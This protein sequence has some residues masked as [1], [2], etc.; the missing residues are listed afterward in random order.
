MAS[1]TIEKGNRIETGKR[2]SLG[3]NPVL[4]GR[5]SY[6]NEP[7]I[8]LSDEHISR[9][10]AEITFTQDTFYI[11]DLNSTNGTSLDGVRIEPGK[12]YQLKHESVIGLGIIPD[13]AC[14]MLRFKETP[15][16]STTRI[17]T[18]TFSETNQIP[19]LKIDA[20]RGE[21]WV[22]GKLILLTKKEY[23]LLTCLYETAGSVC[24]RERLIARVWPEVK[25]YSGVS[26]AAIDQLI[27]RI[28]IKIEPDPKRPTR[29]IIR[30]G[31]GCM[32]I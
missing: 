27:H 7:D 11:C 19:W 32:L 24:E 17:E 8:I 14:I 15:S 3:E 18:E 5:K 4:I 25:D 23:D 21:I 2:Y 16:V 31:F 9:H 10:H 12:Q 26:D 6:G 30:K 13:G 29:L 28:R 22:D 20:K 1:I